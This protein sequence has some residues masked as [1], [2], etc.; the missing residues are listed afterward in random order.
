MRRRAEDADIHSLI[1]LYLPIERRGQGW[2]VSGTN[3]TR[4]TAPG[5]I[6]LAVPEETRL[7]H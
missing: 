2:E 5:P 6:D 3:I 4:K 7:D 1:D